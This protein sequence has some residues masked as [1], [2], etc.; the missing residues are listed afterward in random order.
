MKT[1]QK[2]NQAVV[3]NES[4]INKLKQSASNNLVLTKKEIEVLSQKVWVYLEKRDKLDQFEAVFFKK[5]LEKN[6]DYMNIIKILNDMIPSLVFQ[7]VKRF[8]NGYLAAVF[9]TDE[10]TALA[11][12]KVLDVLAKYREGRVDM[13]GLRSYFKTAFKNHCQKTY[14]A[15]NGTDIRG[16]IRTVGSDEAMN[17]AMNMNLYNPENQYIL[18]DAMQHIYKELK[19]ADIDYNNKLQHFN[20]AMNLQPQYFFDIIKGLM[21]G[22]TAEETCQ[23]ITLPMP[24]YLRQKRL[25]LQHL[26]KTMPDLLKDLSSEFEDQVDN[27]IHAQTVEKRSRKASPENKTAVFLFTKEVQVDK[28]KIQVSLEACIKIVD[29]SGNPVLPP[30]AAELKNV[31]THSLI[32]EITTKN[33]L[34]EVKNNLLNQGRSE[35][36]LKIIEDLSLEFFN[37]FQKQLL[38]FQKNR[39]KGAG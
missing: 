28:R 14:E 10:M 26:K 4:I 1:K 30:K 16:S 21:A 3:L 35:S 34:A 22:N 19:K 36:T 7:V 5:V 38:T 2:Y 37:N 15:H 11:H 6:A 31:Q 18:D 39:Y 33:K 32:T 29:R 9:S 23:E 17:I 12:Q 13:K 8:E 25:A 27:R 24:E 20:S